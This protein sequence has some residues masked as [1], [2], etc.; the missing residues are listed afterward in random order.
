[1]PRADHHPPTEASSGNPPAITLC[2]TNS[3]LHRVDIAAPC[4]NKG[5]RSVGL[6]WWSLVQEVLHVSDAI[7]RE[8][9]WEVT[10]DLC[11]YREPEEVEKEKAVSK[12]E[13]QGGRTA[14]APVRS[15]LL[16]L[17]SQTGLQA[18]QAP[19]VP[20]QQFPPEARCS[21]PAVR[22]GVQLPLFRALSW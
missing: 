8:H 2:N 21:Q 4:N 1:D 15:P 16:N 7:S 13:F 5:A 17:K 11:F 12:E 3:P 9:P 18:Q 20:V 14:P 22:T 6:T 10:P 19:S